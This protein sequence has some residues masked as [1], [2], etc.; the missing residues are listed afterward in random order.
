MA[1]RY[2]KIFPQYSHRFDGSGSY[3]DPGNASNY[4]DGIHRALQDQPSM[5][6][7]IAPSW[8]SNVRKVTFIAML[9]WKENNPATTVD[10]RLSVMPMSSISTGKG[11]S[12]ATVDLAPGPTHLV[13]TS[14]YN[15]AG[16]VWPFHGNALLAGYPDAWM[17]QGVSNTHFGPLTTINGGD[18]APFDITE[19]DE[20]VLLVEFDRFDPEAEEFFQFWD[21]IADAGDDSAFV[22]F[23]GMPNYVRATLIA[24]AL[25]NLHMTAM[26]IAVQQA[27]GPINNTCTRVFSGRTTIQTQTPNVGRTTAFEI[28]PD[29]GTARFAYRAAEWDGVTEIYLSVPGLMGGII[30]P[31]QG[32]DYQL[33]DYP[34][35]VNDA[36]TVLD[37]FS[38]IGMSGGSGMD[39]FRSADM[40]A[41]LN[42]LPDAT[43]VGWDYRLGGFG[44]NSAGIS[45][46]HIHVVQKSCTKSVFVIDIGA[47]YGN[48][49]PSK[50]V[51]RGWAA[52][53]DPLWF[54]D[55][56]DALFTQR[57]QAGTLRHRADANLLKYNCRHDAVLDARDNTPD[58]SVTAL[59]MPEQYTT[60]G[61]AAVDNPQ[62]RYQ[63]KGIS[64]ND[65]LQIAGTRKLF[66]K[67]T[68]DSSTLAGLTDATQG[69]VLWY[70]HTVPLTD[71]PELGPL[72]PLGAFNPE[73]CA[74]TSAGLGDHPG[75][76][77]I[78][79]G[80]T[81]PKHFNPAVPVIE[82][83]GVPTP[84]CDEIPSTVVEDTGASPFNGLGLGIYRYR[85]TLRNCCTL[86]ESDP[87]P[88]NIVV[89]TS[90]A[91]PAAKVTLS[92]ANVRIP[93]DDQ[94]CEICIYRTVLGGNFPVMAK[95]GCFDIA[96]TSL[97]VDDVADAALDFIND[98]LSLLNAPMPCV[99]V[100][101]EFRNRLFGMGDIP[102]L[103]PAGTV[104]VT[105]GSD[106][107]TGDEDVEWDRCLEGKFIQVEGDCRNYE[108]DKVL[109]PESGLSPAI[110]RLKLTDEYEGTDDTQLN[111]ILCGRP[112][113]LY[114]SEPLEP[115]CW[116][117]S[118]FLD[119]EPGDGDRLMGSVANFNRLVIC[120]RRKTYVLT[121]NENPA[122]EVVVPTRI[123]SDIGCIGPRTFAQ[124]ESGSVWLSDRGVVIYDGRSV[125]NVPE[126]EQMNNLFIDPDNDNYVRRDSNGRVIGAVGVFYPKREQYLLLLPTVN[127]TRGADLMLVWDI[128]L[129]NITL[130][131]FCQEFDAMVVAKDSEGNERVYLGDDQG[132]V[133]IYDIGDNDGVGFPNA[134]GTV[135]GTI[136]NLGALGNGIDQ[137]TGASIIGD[138]TATF[139]TG[140]LP[141]LAGLSGIAG[142]SGAVLAG[143]LGMAGACVFVRAPDAPLDSPWIQRV[144]YASTEKVLYVTPNWTAVER[145]QVGWDYM[146]GPIELVSLFK[147][148]NYG[149]DDILKRDWRQVVTHIPED[150]ASILRVELLPDFANSDPE[151][152]TVVNE[153]DGELETGEGRIYD[154]SF[155][156]ARQVRPVGRLIHNYMGVRMRNFAP[157]EPIRVLN[158]HLM[159]TP[160]A[161]K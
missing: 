74:S 55:F 138:T 56:E 27:P 143:E 45:P 61:L 126:S 23:T 83:N 46:T 51:G 18:L 4:L 115:E 49:G 87:N 155:S 58:V 16:T 32:A 111:Y 98:G 17:F 57:R 110:G 158:H 151:E 47:A 123:S 95:V 106:I 22:G 77:V 122:L 69:I 19:S 107:V 113:R 38:F 94:I 40:L 144:V 105:A 117:A 131:K 90:G 30:L 120:K 33:V 104:S 71:S 112:N 85:Y 60:S 159:M 145:P 1:R 73:G 5:V 147:P 119:V 21:A 63:E 101:A 36:Q 39:M 41:I 127:S 136:D 72:F 50:K 86:K 148:S 150:V 152:L 79:N 68:S 11:V 15:G 76:L 42:A 99:P 139:I 118:L 81:T 161:S 108:I 91:S 44:G 54:E 154:M 78:T 134:V 114:I 28:F 9:Q 67:T 135:R 92:F 109:P 13:S 75:L 66:G 37:S 20:Q 142:L 10:M 62:F 128:K 84:F 7:Y 65:P 89:D 29:G 102:D 82:D 141:E 157:E 52:Y 133:W 25:T 146:I 137:P 149:T 26:H 12:L 34:D 100:V 93:G 14:A 70:A 3:S 48:P 116:P 53:F 80:S 8:F 125:R 64:I 59:T 156:K 132:F 140:G 24:G 153:E 96:Q 88:D 160:K 2:S 35:D 97:F 6:N 129:K 124:I 130:L 121:F 43:K 31:A 103:S